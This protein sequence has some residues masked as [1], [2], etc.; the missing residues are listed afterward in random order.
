MDD[1]SI[2]H[3]EAILNK[4]IKNNQ[5]CIPFIDVDSNQQL[6]CVENVL[7]FVLNVCIV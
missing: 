1:S 3:V 2:F 4:R 6:K 7:L 5:V